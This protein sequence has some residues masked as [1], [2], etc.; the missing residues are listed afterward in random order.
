MG[1]M[2]FSVRWALLPSGGIAT[3]GAPFSLIDHLTHL[4]LPSSVLAL[5][6]VA[7]WSRYLRMSL[8][9]TLEE[10]FVQVARAKGLSGRAVMMRH[11]LRNSL[12][13]VLTV[14]A[15]NLPLL[16]TGSIIVETLFA[17]PGIGRLFYDGLVRMDYTRLMGIVFVT[18]LLIASMN[19]IVDVIYGF[20]DPRIRYAR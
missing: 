3:L 1:M 8:G 20:V 4:V 17:W 5:V 7:S 13:P 11:A 19:V 14:V 6:F 16:F 15:L 2:L 18:S 9:E 12:G 10:S